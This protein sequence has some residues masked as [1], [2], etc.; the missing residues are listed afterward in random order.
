M[1]KYYSH[2][3][4]GHCEL[5]SL[6]NECSYRG[7]KKLGLFIQIIYPTSVRVLG[8]KWQV[9]IVYR[10]MKVKVGIML[11]SFSFQNKEN[12]YKTKFLRIFVCHQTK[13]NLTR[14]FCS[15]HVDI[16]TVVKSCQST[17]NVVGSSSTPFHRW[18]LCEC[19]CKCISFLWGCV[20][21]TASVCK[22]TFFL[23]STM[24]EGFFQVTP[25][26]P[27][28]YGFLILYATYLYY[29]MKMSHSKK[30][31]RV[32]VILFGKPEGTVVNF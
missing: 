11:I 25:C 7:P 13:A 6:L 4:Q 30:W 2:A 12:L 20:V 22:R 21:P 23:S 19:A 14:R 10:N 18:K 5:H 16:L 8:T 24:R 17:Q 32:N 26:A 1:E 28:S 9:N 27:C 31:F 29:F 15:W 3:F